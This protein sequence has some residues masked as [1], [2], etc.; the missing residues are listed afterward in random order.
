MVLGTRSADAA[1]TDAADTPI[2][3]IGQPEISDTSAPVYLL[4]RDA[5]TDAATQLARWII[6]DAEGA[7]KFCSVTVEGAATYESARQVASSIAQSSLVKV[8][9]ARACRGRCCCCCRCSRRGMGP[10]ARLRPVDRAVPADGPCSRAHL[11]SPYCIALSTALLRTL[12]A[13]GSVRRGRQLGPHRVRR[14]L[15]RRSV[16]SVSRSVR[17]LAGR[18]AGT[19]RC[20]CTTPRLHEQCRCGSETPLRRPDQRVNCI[21]SRT[22]SA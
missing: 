18:A 14:R 6:R 8:V 17:R 15:R 9:R 16:R 4:F 1:R 20:N 2:G 12:P 3:P 10:G 22:D 11:R 19:Y 21:C 7:T 13:D 5:L